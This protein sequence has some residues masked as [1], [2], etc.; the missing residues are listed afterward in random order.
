MSDN[1]NNGSPRGNLNE[2][3]RFTTDV[4][5][6]NSRNRSSIPPS[7]WRHRATPA[8]VRKLNKEQ[9]KKLGSITL[10]IFF[11]FMYL[12]RKTV[13]SVIWI[14]NYNSL[15]CDLKLR[16]VRIL[17]LVLD[18]KVQNRL[19]EDLCG[20]PLWK[21]SIQTSPMPMSL[22]GLIHIIGK[23]F[24]WE[25]EKE[26]KREREGGEREGERDLYCILSKLMTFD[27]IWT[28]DIVLFI[29]FKNTLRYDFVIECFSDTEENNILLSIL[30]S[31]IWSFF[32]QC[33]FCPFL[34]VNL[35][36]LRFCRKLNAIKKVS[37]LCF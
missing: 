19:Q 29:F 9:N 25:I 24:I 20:T 31:W 26:R 4:V 17:V 6:K 15:L 37:I 5:Q 14:W 36:T 35:I 2:C 16:L 3:D 30:N 1:S 21:R 33:E 8:R 12:G 13:N 7:R 23:W 32:T 28:W 34:H 18:R 10:N 11:R 27:N 22:C